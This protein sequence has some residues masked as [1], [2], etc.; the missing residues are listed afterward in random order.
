MAVLYQSSAAQAFKLQI[1][2][3][4]DGGP[5]DEAFD[6][7]LSWLDTCRWLPSL[8]SQDISVVGL[9]STRHESRSDPITLALF[10]SASH[11]PRNISGVAVRYRDGYVYNIELSYGQGT[12]PVRLGVEDVKPDGSGNI[13]DTAVSRSAIDC[14]N[15]E[16]TRVIKVLDECHDPGGRSFEGL[17]V[18]FHPLLPRVHR[19]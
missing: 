16:Y 18:L 19:G 13:E 5:A 17:K 2:S 9:D 10:G 3:I 14:A 4:S 8:P 7:I 15:G 1:L 6:D 11:N 12:T